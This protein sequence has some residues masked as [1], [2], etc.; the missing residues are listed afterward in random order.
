M[1]L[2]GQNYISQNPSQ[3]GHEHVTLAQPIRCTFVRKRLEELFPREL[4]AASFRSQG[5]SGRGAGGGVPSQYLR[6]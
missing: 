1:R 5:S 6:C 4:G 3:P 2:L